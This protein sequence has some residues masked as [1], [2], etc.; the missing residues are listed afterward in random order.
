[1]V[2]M[3]GNPFC[4]PDRSTVPLPIQG[5]SS[6]LYVR[7]QMSRICPRIARRVPSS[8]PACRRHCVNLRLGRE[9][10][11]VSKT[12]RGGRRRRPEN[13]SWQKPQASDV[14]KICSREIERTPYIE[15]NLRDLG[16]LDETAH[17]FRLQCQHAERRLQPDLALT[18]SY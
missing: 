6:R 9:Q 2:S 17:V 8:M 14:R 4:W 3:D 16:F 7:R 15:K 1:M 12:C 5:T 13:R 11:E 10:T 18:L